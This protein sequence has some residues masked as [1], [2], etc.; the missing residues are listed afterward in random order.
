M[1]VPQTAERIRCPWC[2]GSEIYTRY[3][4]EEWGRPT[5]E[6][7]KLFEMLILEGAQAGL[8]WISILKRREAYREAF[9][10]FDAQKIAAFDAQK[11]EALM[12]NE[13]IIRNRAKIASAIGNARSFLAVKEEKGSFAD[14]IW[15]FTDGRTIRGHYRIGDPVPAETE[16]SRAMS[17]DLKRRGFSFVGPVIC[18]AYMQ[19]VGIV[20]DHYEEC[21]VRREHNL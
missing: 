12:Q 15:G 6:D 16:V 8:A 13:G 19:S 7:A 2:D 9:A 4:D 21:W 3:H 10:G 20:D 1:S 14:Y 18:Y 11:V 17:R 5:R